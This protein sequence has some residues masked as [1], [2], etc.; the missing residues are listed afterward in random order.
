[1]KKG[2]GTTT[3]HPLNPEHDWRCPT[4]SLA[5]HMALFDGVEDVDA[6]FA[7]AR[8]IEADRKARTAAGE[9]DPLLEALAAFMG[10]PLAECGAEG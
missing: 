6:V 10:V 3:P 2:N 7:G 1:M 5:L 9:R 8:A 4:C